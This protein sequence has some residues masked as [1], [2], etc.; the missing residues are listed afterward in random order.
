MKA[1]PKHRILLVDDEPLIRE[2]MSF[3]LVAQGYEVA[4]ATDGFEA[5]LQLQVKPSDLLI[6]D[7]NMPRM[8][9]FELLSI[10]RQ[11][12]PELPVIAISGAYESSGEIP[13]GVMANAF[14]S[15]GGCTLDKIF[16]TVADLIQ[17]VPEARN[18]R[19]NV[20]SPKKKKPAHRRLHNRT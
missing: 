13:S 8:S 15:K 9:G 1:A 5:L 3:L 20:P 2:T 17:Q 14:Y 18:P 12:F 10:V 4:T 7:L 16:R 11:Q 6:S 19:Q